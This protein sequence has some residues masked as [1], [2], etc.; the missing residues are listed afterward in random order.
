MPPLDHQW[1]FI[2]IYMENI[3][4]KEKEIV[5]LNIKYDRANCLLTGHGIIAS[6]ILGGVSLSG[7]SGSIRKVMKRI[8]DTYNSGSSVHQ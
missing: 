5:T 7:A 8:G 6:G 1:D 3:D 2:Q 4:Q